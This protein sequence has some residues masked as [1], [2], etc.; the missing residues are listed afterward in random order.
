MILRSV[1]MLRTGNCFTITL[2]YKIWGC[3]FSWLYIWSNLVKIQDAFSLFQIIL[4]SKK[5]YSN[6]SGYCHILQGHFFTACYTFI[7]SSMLRFLNFYFQRGE[8][9]QQS[10]FKE[11]LFKERF[12]WKWLLFI[13]I[14]FIHHRGYSRNC[15]WDS[16]KRTWFLFNLF[17]Y[18]INIFENILCVSPMLVI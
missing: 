18:T 12:V 9:L 10:F 13:N 3:S 17:I 7:L 5:F 6:I 14:L 16:Y 8:F 15:T 11:W 4:L 1:S 2:K